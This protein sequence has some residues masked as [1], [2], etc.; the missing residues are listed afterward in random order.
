M[1]IVNGFLVMDDNELSLKTN[2]K[3]LIDTL[4]SQKVTGF[5]VSERTFTMDSAIPTE[6]INPTHNFLITL[7]TAA[8]VEFIKALVKKYSEKNP[9]TT[10]TINNINIHNNYAQVILVIET[11]ITQQ[12][13]ASDKNDS[14]K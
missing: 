5:N 8:A 13:I 3:D 4:R 11:H 7:G 2:D 10:T 14:E 12:N 9:A 1:K 6:I